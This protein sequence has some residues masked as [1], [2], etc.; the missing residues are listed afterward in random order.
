MS[1][2]LLHQLPDFL[3][4]QKSSLTP[5]G[6]YYYFGIACFTTGNKKKIGCGCRFDECAVGY[7]RLF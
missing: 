5:E 2:S 7:S 1:L 6:I 3:L 4:R